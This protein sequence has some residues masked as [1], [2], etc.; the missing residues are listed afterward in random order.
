MGKTIEKPISIIYNLY[1]N[2]IRVIFPRK[3]LLKNN[4]SFETQAK[5][6]CEEVDRK[7]IG[8]LSTAQEEILH[9]YDKLEPSYIEKVF[10]DINK[11]HRSYKLTGSPKS[12]S[13]SKYLITWMCFLTTGNT[14]IDIID[15]YYFQ[16][17]YDCISLGS[18]PLFIR[19]S[20]SRNIDLFKGVRADYIE[21]GKPF[22]EKEFDTFNTKIQQI[23]NG[24]FK[25]I[26]NDY[27][28]CLHRFFSQAE[29]FI[30]GT[31]V[32]YYLDTWETEFGKKLIKLNR[33]L[34]S[35]K[36]G[37]IRFFISNGNDNSKLKNAIEFQIKNNIE[38][39]LL[40][41]KSLLKANPK[42]KV[43]E[44][45]F[46]IFDGL[47]INQTIFTDDNIKE[48]LFLLKPDVHKF[49]SEKFSW[50][51]SPVNDISMTKFEVVDK[52][53]ISQKLVRSEEKELLYE[54]MRQMIDYKKFIPFNL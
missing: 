12:Y 7:P 6:F 23:S 13:V 10:R 53:N 26:G 11:M 51:F 25:I 30:I 49:L 33:N 4:P 54:R 50:I 40:S 15:E 17:C 24:E 37:V 21:I 5:Y 34:I 38:V 19:N 1:V 47:K 8:G 46:S 3:E 2:T 20:I 35:N 52:E 41:L 43:K 18:L 31:S 32:P 42:F 36:K 29:E 48:S 28:D 27:Q 39:Y 45:D 44:F 22:L 14:D 9:R 16:N